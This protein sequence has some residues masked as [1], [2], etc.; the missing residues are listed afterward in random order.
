MRIVGSVGIEAMC[1]LYQ[2]LIQNSR[3][4]PKA[5]P[6]QKRC[7]NPASL[8]SRSR[9]GGVGVDVTYASE[10]KRIILGIVGLYLLA[11]IFTTAAEATGHWRRCGCEPDCW[12]QKPGLRLFRWTTPKRAHHQVSAA[13]KEQEAAARAP[14]TD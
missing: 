8:R 5:R 7:A 4:R 1:V 6:A 13:D 12:C 3:L 2:T 11:A 9:A 14:E 10:M